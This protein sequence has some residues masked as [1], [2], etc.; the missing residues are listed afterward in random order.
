MAEDDSRGG[1]QAQGCGFEDPPTREQLVHEVLRCTGLTGANADEQCEVASFQPP[2]QVAG[3][4]QRLLIDPM[5]VVDHEQ[6]R[7]ALGERDGHR[8][9][10]AERLVRGCRAPAVMPQRA[11]RSAGVTDIGNAVQ[12]LA[13]DAERI[14]DLQ[15]RASGGEHAIAPAGGVRGRRL[16]QRG[17]P[18]P[19][20]ALYDEDPAAGKYRGDAGQLLVALFEL[21]APKHRIHPRRVARP[22]P[23]GMR[24]T[25]ARRS[26]LRRSARQSGLSYTV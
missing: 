8:R 2:S 19:G 4:A 24:A 9:E 21:H 7:R 16:E 17:L 12:Q 3:E 15:H 14:G 10:S 5:R 18:D 26:E 6:Q 20:R 22:G 25:R 11:R 1:S 13:H 23:V